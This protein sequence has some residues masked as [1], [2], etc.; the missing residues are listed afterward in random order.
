MIDR[1]RALLIEL[2][3][4]D[5]FIQQGCIDPTHLYCFR[6]S[7]SSDPDFLMSESDRLT[8][9]AYSAIDDLIQM[10]ERKK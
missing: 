7:D 9:I 8:G 1:L 4:I 5:C 3:D 10:M 2:E 6:D